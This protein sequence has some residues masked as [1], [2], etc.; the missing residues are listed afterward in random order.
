MLPSQSSSL[1]QPPGSES[2]PP[3]PGAA[4][5][6]TAIDSAAE[7]VVVMD[8]FCGGNGPLKSLDCHQKDLEGTLNLLTLGKR[9]SV[10]ALR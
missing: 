6:F 3:D 2:I 8:E 7:P 1:T 4:R 10:L 9:A 5:D